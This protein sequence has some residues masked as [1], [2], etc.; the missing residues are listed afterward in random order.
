MKVLEGKPVSVSP[1]N[2]LEALVREIEV[3]QSE[4]AEH[5]RKLEKVHDQLRHSYSRY[6][7]LFEMAPVA[8]LALDRQGRICEVNA[9]GGSLLG[10]ENGSL[11]G[12]PF[13]MFISSP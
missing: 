9:K 13:L 5:R 1:G 3:Y 8:F 2:Q 4:I 10:S 12:Q 6:N 11:T 7:E